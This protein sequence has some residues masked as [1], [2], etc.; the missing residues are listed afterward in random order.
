MRLVCL[1]AKD[2]LRSR[3]PKHRDVWRAGRNSVSDYLSRTLFICSN[4]AIFQR[5]CLK[6]SC[7]SLQCPSFF[8]QRVQLALS[9]LQVWIATNVF[10]GNED[11]GNA[12]LTG[13]FFEGIL[14]CAAISCR[15]CQ[16]NN[17]EV[18][19]LEHLHIWSSSITSY[20]APFSLNRDFEALQ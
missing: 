5:M 8:Q 12:S 15:S 18:W 11:V 2:S 13:D 19:D 7:L 3:W 9:C 1:P 17:K 14:K 4:L 10:L 6:L 16:H 20:F